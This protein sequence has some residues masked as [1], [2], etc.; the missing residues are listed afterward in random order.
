VQQGP[1]AAKAFESTMKDRARYSATAFGKVTH[2]THL[3]LIRFRGLITVLNNGPL[4]FNP[5]G[6]LM[7]SQITRYG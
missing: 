7:S 4:Y 6:A 3:R 2:P 1:N 5:T